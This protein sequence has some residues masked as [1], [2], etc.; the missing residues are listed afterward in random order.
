MAAASLD[1]FR[2][3]VREFCRDQIPADWR[4]AQTGVPDDEFVRFQKDWFQQLRSAGFAVPH[5]PAQW[6]GGMSVPEQVVLYQ[7]LAA[8]D[9]PRLVLAF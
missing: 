4:Q 3:T 2:E 7:E 1:E 8:H 6:G 9:A 5:W